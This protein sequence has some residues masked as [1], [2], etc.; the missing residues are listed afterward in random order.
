MSLEK[1]MEL[2]KKMGLNE[3]QAK[4]LVHLI[5]LGESKA[6]DLSKSSGVPKARIYEVLEELVSMGFVDIKPGR[7][8]LYR[9]RAP[10]EIIERAKKNKKEEINRALSL[11]DEISG[12]L[13]EVLDPLYDSSKVE[14]ELLKIIHVGSA[15]ERETRI[16]YAE[17]KKEINI[18]SKSLEYLH[19]VEG[20]L[21]NAINRGC[22]I[23]VLLLSKDL[24][25][26]HNI[27]I[28]HTI[29]NYLKKNLPKIQIRFSK[30]KLPL[31]GSIIDPSYEYMTG[32]AIFLVEEKTV[33]LFLREAA[34]T[35]NP[36][37]V[38]GMKKYFDLIW[39][40]ESYE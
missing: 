10:Q 38:A 32:K 14:G 31:R 20:D 4:V 37:L 30:S 6:P 3:Y 8:S 12:D 17:A 40:Y 34:F 29:V 33:P 36:S 19:K 25:E 39:K 26:E 27:P 2:F 35:D 22:S 16:L 7:P 28:Q 18:V 23:K 9:S 5:S 24:L 1:G 15:S 11:I 21:K 13:I